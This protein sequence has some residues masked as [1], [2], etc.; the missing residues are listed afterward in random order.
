M[1][2]SPQQSSFHSLCD[3]DENARFGKYSRRMLVNVDE[4]EFC[5]RR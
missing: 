3:E 2:I 1:D 4:T 5:K